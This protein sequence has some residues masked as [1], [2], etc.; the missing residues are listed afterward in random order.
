ALQVWDGALVSASTFSAEEG[1]GD[2]GKLTVNA[3]ESVQLRGTSNFSQFRRSGLFA[4][5][6]GKGEAGEVTINTSALQ[7]WDGARVS[8][9]SL[10]QGSLGGNGG[11]LTV[12]ASESVKLMGIGKI[13]NAPSGLFASTSGIGN[14]GEV[15]INTAALQVWDGA[16]V[17][18]RTFSSLSNA[19]DAGNLTVNASQ[20]VQ[21]SG[22]AAD[23]ISRSQ[24]I[25]STDG[26]GDAGDLTIT[27][28]VLEV[29]DGGRVSATTFNAEMGDAGAAGDLRIFSQQLVIENGA[30]ISAR[31]FGAG[32]AGTLEVN[33][34]ESV[35]ID[36]KDSGLYFD[37][38]GSGDA[39]GIRIQTGQLVVENEGEVTVSGTGS[40]NPG[41]LEAIAHSIFL[42]NQG[43]FTA[44][45]AS[46]EGGNIQL[47]VHDSLLM[48]HNSEISASAEGLGNGGNITIEAPNGLIV[49]VLSENSD[50]VASAN[51]GNGGKVRA[52]AVGVLGFRQFRD[53]RTLESD[54][55]ASSELGIDGTL[56]INTQ[57]RE[58]EVLPENFADVEIAQGCQAVRGKEQSQFIIAG[59]GGL[60]PNP[61]EA[62]SS[63]AVFVDW[64]ALNPER[65]TPDYPP[66][67]T[68]GEIPTVTQNFTY[69]TPV[70]IVEATGW[71]INA[72]GEV[73]LVADAPIISPHSPWHSPTDCA[74]PQS[75][76]SKRA[77]LNEQYQEEGRRLQGRRN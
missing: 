27:T 55:T 5:S 1:A 76:I 28:P 56:E 26:V 40:G 51:Q 75:A 14:G 70:P 58:L 61:R 38:S 63:D 39:L 31:S 32:N 49:A 46:G 47:Q 23:G 36:G 77:E 3:S 68:Q 20:L 24:L 15:T 52:T 8:V 41:N 2:A 59:R 11:R 37:T 34:T 57:D 44:I 48:R 62:L 53:R 54:F 30:K 4:D 45:T 13:P 64:V 50:I 69:P 35:R 21:V 43:R 42:S 72:K 60:P 74:L 33:A 6:L 19:G 9:S 12:N 16:L 22:T 71:V 29:L 67:P 25:A 66:L 65:E 17:S 18:V 7:I 73:I 10:S